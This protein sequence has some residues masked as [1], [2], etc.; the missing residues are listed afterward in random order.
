MKIE[1]Y[2]SCIGLSFPAIGRWKIEI[3][4]CPPSYEIKPH[5][6]PNQDIRLHFIL[7]HGTTFYRQ[8][9][10]ASGPV[11]A[12][13]TVNWWNIGKGFNILRSD[14]HWFTVSKFPLVFFNVEKWYCKPTSA[15]VDFKL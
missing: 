2:E 12:S 11:I 4:Y 9:P 15:A 5:S 14:S 7:G 1:R 8:R 10:T 13:K 3:W 6:H